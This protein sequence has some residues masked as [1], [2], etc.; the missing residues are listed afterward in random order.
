MRQQTSRTQHNPRPKPGIDMVIA[1]RL[2]LT[3]HFAKSVKESA[4]TGSVDCLGKDPI[5]PRETLPVP[6]VHARHKRDTDIPV[7]RPK[8]HKRRSRP[9]FCGLSGHEPMAG[10]RSLAVIQSSACHPAG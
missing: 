8:Y 1:A 3:L 5:A 6:D 7:C 10:R 4:C 2:N 9:P